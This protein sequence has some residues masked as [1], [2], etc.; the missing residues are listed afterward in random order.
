MTINISYICV[1]LSVT[2]MYSKMN[3]FLN[4]V[5]VAHAWF[6]EI[7]FVCTSVYVAP[8]A[9]DNQWHDMVLYRMC[10]IG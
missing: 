2:T 10:V 9:I 3:I 5:R 7:V 1:C 6:L 8:E 4:Q